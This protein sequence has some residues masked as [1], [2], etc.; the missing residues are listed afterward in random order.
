[1]IL[2]GRQSARGVA[3]GHEAQNFDQAAN[4]AKTL[5]DALA[6]ATEKVKCHVVYLNK[7]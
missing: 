1:M 7:R 4:Y 6:V 5:V 2:I 3:N